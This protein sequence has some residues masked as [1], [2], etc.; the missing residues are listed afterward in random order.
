ML[1]LSLALMIVGSVLFGML[2][3]G[4]LAA[5]GEDRERPE[6]AVGPGAARRR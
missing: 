6:A 2:L 5:N 3:S 1:W 4:L